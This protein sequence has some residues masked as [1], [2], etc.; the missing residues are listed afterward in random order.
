MEQRVIMAGFGGQ[1]IMSMGQLLAYA[2]MLENKKVSWLPSYGP[3]QR[4]GTANCHV[5]VTDADPGSP[6]VT[7]PTSVIAMNQPSMEK[8]GKRL[9]KGGILFINSSLFDADEELYQS[10]G[11][12]LIRIKANDVANAMEN[13]RIANMVMLGAFIRKTGIV[14]MK[15]AEEA[16]KKVMKG[17]E[18]YI[19]LNIK[20]MNYK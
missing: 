9:N 14:D 7:E 1:G 16:L 6:Y 15:S 20:A 2:G 3:E 10:K 4:G 5:V 13:L 19:P 12:E 11:I 8:F 17:K 18:K